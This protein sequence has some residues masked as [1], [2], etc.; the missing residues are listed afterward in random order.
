MDGIAGGVDAL[1]SVALRCLSS[2]NPSVQ[3]NGL[4]DAAAALVDPQ[5]QH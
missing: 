2:T 3:T 5:Q 1:R 4:S